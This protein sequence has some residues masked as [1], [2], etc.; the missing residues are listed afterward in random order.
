MPDVAE[1]FRAHW[2]AYAAKFGRLI[3]PEQRAAAG[4]PA[5]GNLNLRAYHQGGN[6][7]VEIEDDGAGLNRERILKKAIER[8]LAGEGDALTDEQVFHF[9]F[10]A[11]FSTAEKVTDLSGRGVGLDVVRRNIVALQNLG[12]TSNNPYG[13]VV[14]SNAGIDTVTTGFQEPLTFQSNLTLSANVNETG[15]EQTTGVVVYGH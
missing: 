8:G 6:I 9:I 15:V 2:P 14:L 11:G 12:L 1:I 4:K 5:T 3:P 10:A 7:I 13:I